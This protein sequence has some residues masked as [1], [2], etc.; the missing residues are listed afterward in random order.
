MDDIKPAVH[1][2]QNLLRG[3]GQVMLQNSAVSGALFLVAI[4]I[5]SL[6]LAL[7]ALLGTLISTATAKW[8]KANSAAINQG[9]F[10]FNGTLVGIAVLVFFEPSLFAWLWLVIAAALSTFVTASLTQ[11]LSPA[12]LSTFTA[13]FVIVSWMCFLAAAYLGR[14]EP[15]GAMPAASLP[16]ATAVEGRVSLMVIFNG[17]FNG[18]GQV[19]FQENRLTGL[20]FLAGLAIHSWRPAAVAAIGSISGLVIAWFAGANAL[21]I[22]AG[23]YGFN[24]V[25]VAIALTCLPN[26]KIDTALVALALLL[27]PLVSA[28]LSAFLQPTGLPAL[29]MPFVLV[30]WLAIL[31]QRHL[32]PSPSIE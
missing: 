31:A 2:S 3:I 16:I 12:R 1:F 9:L 24:G 28:A 10:G 22:E 29:T 13:P 15:S 6:T 8:L 20:L 17:F 14:L 7:A 27:T 5:N 23:I 19:F 4:A 25:L 21:A 30:T 26:L 32:T 18:V 11:A